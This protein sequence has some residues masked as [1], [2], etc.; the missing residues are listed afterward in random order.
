MPAHFTAIS[1]TAACVA[2]ALAFLLKW[3]PLRRLEMLTPWLILIAGIGFA[4][5]FLASWVRYVADLGGTIPI[6]GAAITTVVAL[7][8]AY[9][10]VYDLWPKHPS[11]KTTEVAAFL[12]PSVAPT[13]GGGVGT[14]LGTALSWVATAGAVGLTKLFGV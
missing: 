7:V 6:L 12:L 11:N 2:L 13:L 5:P 14:V 9:I 4:A 3:K 10:V 8:L 1:V